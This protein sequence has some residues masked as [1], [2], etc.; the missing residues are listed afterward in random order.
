MEGDMGM[1]TVAWD[2]RKAAWGI[3]RNAD[4]KA[5]RIVFE[6]K[7][8]KV[9]VGKGEGV[10]KMLCVVT[11][12]SGSGKSEYAERAAVHMFEA[13]RREGD[14]QEDGRD[15]AGAGCARREAAAE[16]SLADGS[17][18]GQADRVGKLYYVATMKPYDEECY[19]RIARHRRMRSE[20]GFVTLECPCCIET[21]EAGAKDVFLLE[22]LSNLLANERYLEEGRIRGNG[23]EAQRQAAE[24]VLLPILALARSA[25]GVVVVT[26]EIFSDGIAYEAETEVYRGLLGF[27]NAELVKAADSVVEVVCSIPV[28]QKGGLP[29]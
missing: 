16:A 21:V 24:A 10:G 28:C 1:C 15:E 25:G 9:K 14:V 27:L 11:G 3:C 22:D 26:N 12:G 7:M 5:W 4:R 8:W 29:C 2:I 18:G 6:R 19:A 13:L 20:K 23:E 17:G